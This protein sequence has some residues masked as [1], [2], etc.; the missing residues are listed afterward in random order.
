M[1]DISTKEDGDGEGDK[2]INDISTVN[3]LESKVRS[4]C[5]HFPVVFTQ[6]R[7]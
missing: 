5:R 2:A 4:Y 7:G 1:N 6:A 3:R